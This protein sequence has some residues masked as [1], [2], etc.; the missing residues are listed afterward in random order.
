M[1]TLTSPE[2]SAIDAPTVG[3]MSPI[4]GPKLR[5]AH[6]I[7]SGEILNGHYGSCLRVLIYELSEA[8]YQLADVRPHSE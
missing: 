1:A 7:Q 2:L 6:D 8:A 3:E 4:D 5:V